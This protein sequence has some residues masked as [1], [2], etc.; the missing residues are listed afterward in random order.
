MKDTKETRSQNVFF[1]VFINPIR[2]DGLLKVLPPELLSTIIALATFIDDM[3]TCY[4]TIRTLSSICGVNSSTT[5]RRINRL[6]DI[7]FKGRPVIEIRKQKVQN[8]GFSRNKYELNK[9]MGIAIFDNNHSTHRRKQCTPKQLLDNTNQTHYLK[10]DYSNETIDEIKKVADLLVRFDKRINGD[11]GFSRRAVL[12]HIKHFGEEKWREL[13]KEMNRNASGIYFYK[14]I[15][16]KVIR[17]KK[18][19]E[20]AK[21]E[22]DSEH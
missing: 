18:T 10:Q 15:T 7:R 16:F 20:Q 6:K 19:Y 3:N 22:W 2:Y 1:K 8:S 12:S 21:Q 9:V 14:K 4:P 11:I 17:E 13:Y 5:Q